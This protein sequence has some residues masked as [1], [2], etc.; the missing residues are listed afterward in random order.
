MIGW[1]V[2]VGIALFS[3]LVCDIFLFGNGG[4]RGGGMGRGLKVSG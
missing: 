1:Y 3:L 2:A 4:E